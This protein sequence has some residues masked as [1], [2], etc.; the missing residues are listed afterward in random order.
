MR[1]FRRAAT[2]IRKLPGVIG[3]FRGIRHRGKRWMRE[4][5]LTCFVR[6]KVPRSKLPTSERIPKRIDGIPTDVI[7][8]DRPKL[9]ADVDSQDRFVTAY[10]GL[11]RKSAISAT[12]EHPNGGMIALGSGHGVLPVDNG[13]YESGRW[14]AGELGVVVENESVEPGA[15]WFGEIGND[16]DFS[17]LRFP[18]LGP[19][20]CLSGHLLA[21]APIRLAPRKIANGDYVQHIAPKRGYHI[22]GIVIANALDP[23]TLYSENKI[24]V[25]YSNLIAVAADSVPFSVRTE[26]G[27]LVF[28]S[29]R[30]AVGFVVG[31]GHDSTKGL[32][33]T[34]VLR[35]FATLRS[36]LG[37]LFD[38]FF[39]KDN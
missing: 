36:H 2:R 13:H 6:E 11:D 39:R 3:V 31:G 18:S 21:A 32:D 20:S 12:V 27:S 4:E 24:G 19:P 29:E 23:L 17:V 35:D 33:V 30:R 34:F 37:E 38:L 9:H 15:L 28:D 22:S 26:S 10:D 16:A 14:G 8:L 1:R 7:A 5:T 25:E